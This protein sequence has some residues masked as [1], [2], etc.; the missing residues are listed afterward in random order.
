MSA[1]A[2]HS[3]VF[4]AAA[5]VADLQASGHCL[6]AY[7]PVP[8]GGEKARP[9][10]YFIRPPKGGFGAGYIAVMARWSKAMDVCPDHVERV[11][12]YVFKRSRD[13]HLALAP[14]SVEDPS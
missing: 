2:D 5:F 10:S 1:I 9:P 13:A 6:T 3:A 12:D 7:W 4:D 8:R 14:D 11:V